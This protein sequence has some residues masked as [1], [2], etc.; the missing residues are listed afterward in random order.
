MARKYTSAFSGGSVATPLM[1]KPAN[2]APNKSSPLQ[3]GMKTLEYRTP[4]PV[5]GP[6]ADAARRSAVE[7]DPSSWQDS[8]WSNAVAD[9]LKSRSEGTA[10][11]DTAGRRAAEDKDRNLGLLGEAK[12]NALKST[13]RGANRQGLFYSGILGSRLGDVEQDY[14]RRNTDVLSAFQ[15]G[16]EDRASART[17]L[18][19]TL[20]DAEKRAREEAIARALGRAS[21]APVN[22]DPGEP[23]LAGGGGA[24]S[25]YSDALLKLLSGLNFKPANA[26]R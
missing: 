5:I 13:T 25:S 18:T 15:R 16:E 6:D 21:G 22:E 9:I 17:S 8:A 11:I 19:S 10:A 1:K 24:S 4:T 7:G 26:R 2:A 23:G 3:P 14:G 12:G 20:D